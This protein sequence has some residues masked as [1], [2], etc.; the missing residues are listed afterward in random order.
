LPTNGGLTG[1]LGS[2]AAA[3]KALT[4]GPN[5]LTAASAAL[6]PAATTHAGAYYPYYGYYGYYGYGLLDLF[7]G[8]IYTIF[9]DPFY[10][11][12][13]V[14]DALLDLPYYLVGLIP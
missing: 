1:L 7:Y 10:L 11:P 6:S 14:I 8:L 3:A 9:Y 5:A 12:Y 13:Y 4:G 2:G